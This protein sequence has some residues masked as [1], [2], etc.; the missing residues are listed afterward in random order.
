MTAQS[1][2]HIWR[3]LLLFLHENSR[4]TT[5]NVVE[6]NIS[7]IAALWA[8]TAKFGHFAYRKHSFSAV[9]A[10]W[11]FIADISK[12]WASS[13]LTAHTVLSR[14]RFQAPRLL[15][16][17]NPIRETSIFSPDLATRPAVP[18]SMP[19][20]AKTY[21]PFGSC[22]IPHLPSHTF[23]TEYI[24]RRNP[25]AVGSPVDRAPRLHAGSRSAACLVRCST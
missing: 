8:A 3:P 6:P 18:R 9:R 19:C 2:D 17:T 5:A 14:F 1:R 21:N 11:C 25:T 4:T 24:T 20:D 7:S 15:R 10:C 13:N 16:S 22:H 23:G 12:F